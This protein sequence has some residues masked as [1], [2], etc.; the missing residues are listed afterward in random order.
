[1]A[2]DDLIAYRVD[3]VEG[4]AITQEGFAL[5]IFKTDEGKNLAL[6][7]PIDR[8]DNLIAAAATASAKAAEESGNENLKRAWPIANVEVR[9][10]AGERPSLAAMLFRLPEGMELGFQLSVEHARKVGGE[11]AE[12]VRRASSGGKPVTH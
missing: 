9:I 3:R 7:I 8:M 2:E 6:A 4:S 10:E 1:M 11:L 12:F 5:I